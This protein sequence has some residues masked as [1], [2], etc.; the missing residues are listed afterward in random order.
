MSDI[1]YHN[2]FGVSLHCRSLVKLTTQGASIIL[3]V[4]L[5]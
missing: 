4:R 5:K 1:D 2:S 3:R